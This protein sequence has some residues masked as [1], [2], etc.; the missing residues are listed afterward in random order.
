MNAIEMTKA[1]KN[2]TEAMAKAEAYKAQA[3]EARAYIE[4]EMIDHNMTEF[5]TDEGIARVTDYTAST[6]NTTAFKKAFADLYSQFTKQ[7][8]KRRFS[9]TH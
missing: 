8:T 4:K 3:E 7:T 2:Y 9:I 1:M 6:F 5:V